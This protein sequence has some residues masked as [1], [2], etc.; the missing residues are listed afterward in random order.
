MIQHESHISSVFGKLI[1]TWKLSNPNAIRGIKKSNDSGGDFLFLSTPEK[2]K[3]IQKYRLK[4]FKGSF[5]G[6]TIDLSNMEQD[7]PKQ[8][9]LFPN[10]EGFYV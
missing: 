4:N 2:L 10:K 6:Q 3:A 5:S 8:Q 7:A 9:A 1:Q